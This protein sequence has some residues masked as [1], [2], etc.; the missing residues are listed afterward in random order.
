MQDDI[1]WLNASSDFGLVQF[2]ARWRR[3][4][5]PWSSSHA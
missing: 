5:N 4:L 1:D 2:A 3:S